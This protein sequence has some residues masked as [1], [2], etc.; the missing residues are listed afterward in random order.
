MR[1]RKYLRPSIVARLPVRFFI[2]V[3]DSRQNVAKP[4][5]IALNFFASYDW[6]VPVELFS[7]KHGSGINKR[8][9]LAILPAWIGRN[10]KITQQLLVKFAANKA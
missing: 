7:V 8:M 1:Q 5:A 2:D 9:E 10:G 3:R 6:N 4:E